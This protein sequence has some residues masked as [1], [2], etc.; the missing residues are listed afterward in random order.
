MAG[1]LK[2]DVNDYHPDERVHSEPITYR[3]VLLA[4]SVGH[5]FGTGFLT[6]KQKT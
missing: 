6:N 4:D 3:F 5:F 1:R 2:H